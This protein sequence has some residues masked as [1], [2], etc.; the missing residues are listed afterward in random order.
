[1]SEMEILAYLAQGNKQSFLDLLILYI[2]CRYCFF[3]KVPKFPWWSNIIYLCHIYVSPQNNISNL[4][5]YLANRSTDTSSH[6]NR[7]FHYTRQLIYVPWGWPHCIN[8]LA[9][10]FWAH[11]T[12]KFYWFW[13]GFP[14]LWAC[15]TLNRRCRTHILWGTDLTQ[16]LLFCVFHKM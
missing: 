2:C 10:S 5:S 9:P 15:W 8:S 1:M 16:K 7:K 13:F 4:L 6:R 3:S 11:F 14:S 12:L